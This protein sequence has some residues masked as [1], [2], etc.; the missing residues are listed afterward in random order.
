MYQKEDVLPYMGGMWR[1]AI[2]SICGI[3]DSYFNKRHGPCPHCGGRDRWRW[4]DKINVA[5]DG[6]A[7]C[8]SC[9][10][11]SGM[12]WL[13]KL[14]GQPY[15]ECVNI[16]GDFLG[17]VP[18]EYVVKQNTRAR[19]DAGYSFSKAIPHEKCEEIMSRTVKMGD[20]RLA[21]FEAISA[22]GL[23]FDVGIRPD[24]YQ[25]HAAPCRLVHEDGLDD[26][27]CNVMMIGEDGRYSFAAGVSTFA[28]VARIGSSEKAIY[29]VEDWI[30]GVRVHN[31]TGQEVWVCFDAPNIETVAFRY[32]GGRELRVACRDTDFHALC[33][34]EE[35]NLRVVIP[36][37]GS[38]KKGLQRRLF[39]PSSLLQN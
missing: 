1:D 14:T 25:I 13:M 21:R 27:M 24:G 11:D 15:S 39:E 28:S 18:R 29:L 19:R 20:T 10:N 35:R 9:G 34:A 8:N 23:E 33:S 5:G 38:F 32:R 6:G 2:Q 37:G 26:E 30:D 22:D 7:V 16:L 36:L 12:G 31:A 4:T 3:P 17:K